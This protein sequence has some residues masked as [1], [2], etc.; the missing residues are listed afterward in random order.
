M[1]QIFPFFNYEISPKIFDVSEP[2][3]EYLGSATKP[4]ISGVSVSLQNIE[5]APAKESLN[6]G[7]RTPILEY[8]VY[9]NL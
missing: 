6:V 3:L 8:L 5:S 4:G 7:D 1:S 9:A 2:S